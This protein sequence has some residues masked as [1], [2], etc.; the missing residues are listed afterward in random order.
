VLALLPGSRAQEIQTMLPLM[1]AAACQ[2]PTL[3]PVIAGAPNQPEA[4][5]EGI[6]RQAGLSPTAI[7]ISRNQTYDLLRLSSLALVT[8]GTATL[9]TALLGIPQVVCYRGSRISYWIARRLVRHIRFIALPNL[10]LDRA[11][12]PE[13][14]QGEL[15]PERLSQEIERIQTPEVCMQCA[16]DYATLRE[17]LGG[18]GASQRLAESLLADLE[19]LRGK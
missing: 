16:A 1:L 7:P 13:L 11:I 19:T 3:Q 15:T 18:T 6:L 17:A 5:Y 12:V 2:H 8:S 4:F 10:I 14:I 9:E